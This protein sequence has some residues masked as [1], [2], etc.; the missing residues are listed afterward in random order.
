MWFSQID[1]Y[2]TKNHVAMIWI[3]RV[4]VFGRFDDVTTNICMR[5]LKHI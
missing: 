1:L 4:S 5:S 2:E 3:I